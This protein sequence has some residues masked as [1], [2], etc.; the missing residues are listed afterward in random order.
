MWINGLNY[1]LVRGDLSLSENDQD[2]VI[3]KS[4]GLPTYH[5]AH[6]VD[7]H[8]MHTNIVSNIVF[9]SINT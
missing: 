7:D 2:I 4:D 6:L 5:F 9:A 8:F 3:Y 1:D